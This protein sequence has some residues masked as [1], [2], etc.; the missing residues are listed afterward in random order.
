MTYVAITLHYWGKAK[1]QTAALA[2]MR[3]AGGRSK[4]RTSVLRFVSETS[5][6]SCGQSLLVRAEPLF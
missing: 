5:N 4:V 2:H 3:E 1:T 6:K